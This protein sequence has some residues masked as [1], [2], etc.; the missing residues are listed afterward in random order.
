MDC[1]QALIQ[2]VLIPNCP[3]KEFIIIPER[4]DKK[5]IVPVYAMPIV[6]GSWCKSRESLKMTHAAKGR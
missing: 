1:S 3:D 2:S 6:S 5:Q 4:T